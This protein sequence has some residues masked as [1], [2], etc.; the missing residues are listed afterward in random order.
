MITI[1]TRQLVL[2]KEF[3]AGLNLYGVAD[4]ILSNPEICKSLFVKLESEND[5]I[6]ANELFS[7]V[8]PQYLELGSS[9]RQVE[10]SV[11]DH[12]QDSF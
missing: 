5:N 9:Q 7:M 10:E 6:S 1:V 11:M 3:M 8:E 2:M 12:L 4:I